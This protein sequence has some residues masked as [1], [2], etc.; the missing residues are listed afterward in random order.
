M[1]VE[2]GRAV[3]SFGWRS[4]GR[5]AGFRALGCGNQ[6][7][8]TTTISLITWCSTRVH[9]RKDRLFCGECSYRIENMV[10]NKAELS[11]TEKH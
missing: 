6:F 10:S 5:L 9:G 11:Q 8:V 4:S 7:R 1:L 2:A 3:H